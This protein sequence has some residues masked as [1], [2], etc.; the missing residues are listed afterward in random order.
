M[1]ESASRTSGCRVEVILVN[2][3]ER[4]RSNGGRGVEEEE[5]EEDVSRARASSSCGTSA[6]TGSISESEGYFTIRS[7]GLSSCTTRRRGRAGRGARRGRG[8]VAARGSF[9]APT[10]RPA[11]TYANAESP[12]VM[13]GFGGL[14]VPCLIVANKIDLEGRVGRG[15]ERTAAPDVLIRCS[16][17]SAEEA[18][19]EIRFFPPPSVTP[20]AVDQSLRIVVHHPSGRARSPSFLRVE[21]YE[22]PSRSVASSWM[23]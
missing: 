10:E 19:T 8:E 18:G 6:D 3:D 17:S 2:G 15:D 14:P 16:T 22:R 13:Y 20:R 4:G 5:E 21:A 7:T 11:E 23:W 12:S 9:S 1:G